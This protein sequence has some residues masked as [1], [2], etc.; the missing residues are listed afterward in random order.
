MLTLL[1][2]REEDKLCGM[3]DYFEASFCQ[4]YL[5]YFVELT[6]ESNNDATRL[7][8]INNMTLHIYGWTNRTS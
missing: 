8:L 3:R 5:L 4:N 2:D 7:T 6:P 1:L